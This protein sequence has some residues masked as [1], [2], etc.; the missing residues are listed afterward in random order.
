MRRDA[1]A[2]VHMSVAFRR[3]V[4]GGVDVAIAYRRGV[5]GDVD[6]SIAFR[7]VGGK[8]G[9][10]TSACWKREART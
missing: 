5:A 9:P 4:A 3:G 2:F 1:S 8:G 6:M 7:N 10:G